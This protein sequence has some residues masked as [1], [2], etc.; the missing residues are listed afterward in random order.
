MAVLCCLLLAKKSYLLPWY[1][2]FMRQLCRLAL[3]IVDTPHYI[4]EC[5]DF[6]RENLIF[7]ARTPL[8]SVLQ[9]WPL[10]NV[11]TIA[12]NSIRLEDILRIIL[13][14]RTTFVSLRECKD[15]TK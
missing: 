12:N 7:K 11:P 9:S 2:P 1:L 3:E 15:L 10:S 8:L 4:K 14:P 5:N 13:G 6:G